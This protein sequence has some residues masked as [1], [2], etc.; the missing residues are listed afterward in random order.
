MA[1]SNLC[2]VAPCDGGN[3]ND[4][5]YAEQLDA[6]RELLRRELD[7]LRPAL[8]V[9]LAGIDWFWDFLAPAAQSQASQLEDPRVDVFCADLF[10][11]KAV[12][13]PHPGTANRAGVGPKKLGQRIEDLLAGVPST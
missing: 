13:A 10:G 4:R 6:C 12:F 11:H 2:K 5:L 3:P 9:V 7:E 8:T 1:W